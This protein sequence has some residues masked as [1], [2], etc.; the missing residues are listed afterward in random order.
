MPNNAKALL[1]WENTPDTPINANNLSEAIDFQSQG[2]FLK[3]TNEADDYIFWADYSLNNAWPFANQW[4]QDNIYLNKII[5]NF[6]DNTVRRLI[7][8]SDTE[9]KVWEYLP[10]PYKKILKIKGGTKISTVYTDIATNESQVMNFNFSEDQ[11]FTIDDLF[12]EGVQDYE[13]STRYFV[14]IYVQYSYNDAAYIKVV[15][16]D[17]A[18]A[19]FWK[20]SYTQATSPTGQNLISYR[21]LGGFKT[22]SVGAID[23]ESIWDLY[24]Y[25]DEIVAG[26]IKVW[27]DGES[28]PI[29]A[30][31]F[32]IIDTE[33][34]FSVED[35]L[36]VEEAL[37]QTRALVNNLNNRFYTNRR[38]GFNLQFAPFQADGTSLVQAG[39]NA[40][41]LRIT[42][43]FLDVL[44][45]QVT[46]NEI[47]WFD[48]DD[49]GFRINDSSA[50]IYDAKLASEDNGSGHVLY[51]GI[52][53]VYIDFNG[54]FILRHELAENGRP[55]WIPHYFG[56]F[57]TTG[58]RALGKFKVKNDN[59]NYIENFSVTDTFEQNVPTNSIHI[60][61]GTLCPDGL[62]PCDGK[63]H[64]IYGIDQNAYEFDEIPA[65]ANWGES[66]YVETPN[67]IHTAL[68]GADP[69]FN[70][71]TSGPYNPITNTGGADDNTLLG[72]NDTHK[73]SF[74]HNHE[75]GTINILPSGIHP[76]EH[77][78]DFNGS[79]SYVEVNTIPT[80]TGQKVSVY[81][82]TH[83]MTITGGEHSH[84]KENFSGN[85]ETLAGDEATTQPVSSWPTYREAL[86]CI[87]KV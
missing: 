66:W 10:T 26:K 49:F 39:I 68:R 6:Y 85:T 7:I 51:P 3:F 47:A 13:P 5:Y 84:A 25:R 69:A 36:T 1:M 65:I 82:H 18:D 15:K 43:G 22:D 45:T 33:N 78:V 27:K 46:R 21:K 75:S 48:A 2:K 30:S 31:D 67:Y 72:G 41:T 77:Q 74:P 71:I 86:V 20:T 61:Y 52:W 37:F 76:G 53:T 9:Q 60:H 64:D 57:D 55:R 28:R 59:G 54:Q 63:W 16:E 73:H 35:Q 34:L 12:T 32:Q 50:F 70:M 11:I 56:W 80:G 62:L 19:S 8:D 40:I 79:T 42:P 58:K 44:G 29:S 24:T 38:F 17:D 83:N 23:E 14:Y 87:K 81:N 4:D